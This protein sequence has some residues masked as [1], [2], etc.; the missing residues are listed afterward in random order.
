MKNRK[1]KSK[2]IAR[3]SARKKTGRAVR[4]KQGSDAKQAFVTNSEQPSLEVLRQNYYREITLGDA[5][6]AFGGVDVDHFTWAAT[7]RKQMEC[8][9]D[10][11]P[12]IEDPT[13]FRRAVA[14]S[15]RRPIERSSFQERALWA[16]WALQAG[17]WTVAWRFLWGTI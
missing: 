7:F 10:L 1:P 2:K 15:M 13:I 6:R 5:L 8:A 11:N 4:V 12:I 16:A 3:A 17:Q 14:R 9:F